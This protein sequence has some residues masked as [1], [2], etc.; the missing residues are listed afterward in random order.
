MRRDGLCVVMLLLLSCRWGVVNGQTLTP[1]WQFGGLSND[2]DGGSPGATMIQGRDGNFYGTSGWTNRVHCTVFKITPDGTLTTLWQFGSLSNN[3]DGNV[4]FSGLVQGR[5]GDFYGTTQ[6]GGTN[7]HFGTVFKITSVGTFTPL[8]QFGSVFN[9]LDGIRPIGGLVQGSDGNFYGTTGG[10]ASFSQGTVFRISPDGNLTTLHTFGSFAT[11]GKSPA[12][13]LV[14]G[15]D[16]NFYGTTAS[17][18]AFGQGTL[19]QITPAGVLTNIW[20]FT[21]GMDG[22]LCLAALVEG[23]DGLFYGTTLNGGSYNRGTIFKITSAGTLTP[24]WQFGSLSNGGDGYHPEAA[25]VLGSDGDFYGTASGGG[26]N[27]LYSYGTVFKITSDGTLTPLWQFASLS[28]R[29]D[30]V[31]PIGGL[32][33]G[34][35][36]AFYGTTTFGGTNGGGAYG[37]VFK[38]CVPLNPPANQISSLIL[39]DSNIVVAVPSVAGETYQLQYRA[40]LTSG[41]WSNIPGACVSNSIGALLTMTNCA[42]ASSPQ[43]FYRFDITP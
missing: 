9:Y 43:G 14:Q 5:D 35:D 10:Y 42:G 4:L 17:G 37:T 18:G 6:D 13:S 38:L 25:L 40:D 2:A 36:G 20:N 41:D 30:G 22:S 7:V 8:W 26:T 28:N 27:G 33:Q 32:V 3:A 24:L 39:A 34:S 31:E 11:D 19:F 16:G 21:G 1:L 12:T 23:P 15:S 29:A